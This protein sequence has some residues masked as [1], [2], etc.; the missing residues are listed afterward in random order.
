MQLPLIKSKVDLSSNTGNAE[1]QAHAND[2]IAAAMVGS[3]SGHHA[4]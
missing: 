3:M 1:D 4:R 2:W